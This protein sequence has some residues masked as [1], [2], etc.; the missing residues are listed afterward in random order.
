M[1]DDRPPREILIKGHKVLVDEEDFAFL[2]RFNWHVKPDKNTCYAAT[3]I[4]FGGKRTSLLMHR[5]LMC[6]SQK[7]V[8]HINGNGLDNRKANLR[9]ANSQQNA[10]NRRTNNKHGYRGVNN[11]RDK[12]YARSR[13]K[14]KA[15]YAGP[16]LTA[17]EAAKAYDNMII[18]DHGEYAL[19]NFP[20]AWRT[21]L[22]ESGR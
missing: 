21:F 20:T 7:M 22:K 14:G 17:A 8:D 16:F 1:Q 11:W 12:F 2:A 10:W 6:L 13:I 19:L 9:F 15:R 18:K 5:L 4:F 3:P